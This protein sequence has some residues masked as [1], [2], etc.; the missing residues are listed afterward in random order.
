MKYIERTIQQAIHRVSAGFPVVLITGPRQVGKTTVFRNIDKSRNYVSLDVQEHRLLAQQNPGLFLQRFKAPLLIDEIQYAPQLFPYIKSIVDEAHE[1]GMYWITGSQQFQLMKN[2]S[3][4]LAGRVGILELQGL[5][6]REI[7]GK[8]AQEKFIP[9]T[10]WIEKSSCSDDLEINDLF[11]I[12]WRGFYPAL[13]QNPKLDWED[14][15]ASY[16]KTYIERDIHDLMNV[17]D[18]LSFYRFITAVASR[19]GQLLNYADI[20]RDIKKNIPTVQRWMSLLITSGLVYLLYPYGQSISNRMTKMPKIY[21]MDTGLACYLTKWNTPETLMDGAKCGEMLETFVV[22]SILK[23]Y[24]HNG[25]NPNISF[26]RDKEKKEIDLLI[27][28]NGLV[29]PIEIKKSSNPGKEAMKNFSVLDKAKLNVGAGAIICLANTH[30]P[31]TD[32]V[33]IIPVKYL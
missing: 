1:P 19:T 13:Y 24:W 12:I 30:L 14:F 4:S 20:A 28:E 22:A 25:R 27:E 10:E 17:S 15:Y 16:V 31:L 32:K 26:Y 2:V 21:F 33:N 23:S 3:E 9:T 5:S 7:L 18:E 29:Y 8:P 6:L 11:K